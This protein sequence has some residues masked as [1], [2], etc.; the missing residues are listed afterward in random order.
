[1]LT[2]H[3]S[4][5]LNEI[6][7]PQATEPL[8]N[9]PLTWYGTRDNV[10]HCVRAELK[11]GRL[12]ATLVLTDPYCMAQAM[13]ED[14]MWV[15][16]YN[17]HFGIA[18]GGYRSPITFD[19]TAPPLPVPDV[20][21]DDPCT[22]DKDFH[23]G[24]PVCECCGRRR[25][26]KTNPKIPQPATLKEAMRD[27]IQS[28]VE[29][30]EKAVARAIDPLYEG[31]TYWR[32][33][34]QVQLDIAK[35]KL[36]LVETGEFDFTALH[37][38]EKEAMKP[39]DEQRDLVMTKE[40]QAWERLN[41]MTTFYAYDLS[42]RLQQDDYD[43]E[44]RKQGERRRATQALLEKHL[45][46]FKRVLAE[47][48]AEDKIIDHFTFQDY[49]DA[50][51]YS[52]PW[53]PQDQCRF[54]PEEIAAAAPN[55]R[56]R[57]RP[58]GQLESFKRLKFY[59]EMK[60]SEITTETKFPTWGECREDTISTVSDFIVRIQRI[61]DNMMKENSDLD[62]FY[63]AEVRLADDLVYRS[64]YFP[65]SIT[66]DHKLVCTQPPPTDAILTVGEDF[67]SRDRKV[68]TAMGL[69]ARTMIEL[70]IELN[71]KELGE[72]RYPLVV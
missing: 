25:C 44:S 9:V 57:P 4:I 19:P 2:I 58:L 21:V 43:F 53:Y 14:T 64:G 59:P 47:L 60:R 54:T 51:V 63:P 15:E 29:G 18:G 41:A 50:S 8:L 6:E 70:G 31:D 45:A 61:S 39:L 69:F 26:R 17:P 30:W 12:E 11:E 65:L 5:P 37:K 23:C 32:D 3:V 62:D 46:Y 72:Q 56:P 16:F 27:M 10:G 22:C 35:K 68:T 55:K 1:M 7:V 20:D 36:A 66:T 34:C 42:M 67:D 49:Y 13:G 33:R 28:N 48:K 24:C 40:R 71:T 52:N 38:E